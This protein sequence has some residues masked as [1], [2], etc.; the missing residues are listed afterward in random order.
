MIGLEDAEHAAHEFA[1]GAD[2]AASVQL[3]DGAA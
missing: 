1:L 2:S 3:E